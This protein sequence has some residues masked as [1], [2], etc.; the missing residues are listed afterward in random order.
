MSPENHI[1]PRIKRTHLLLRDALIALIS[2][3]SYPAISVQEITE[4]ATLNRATF[5]K[6]YQDKDDLLT[7]SI[8][9]ILDEFINAVKQPLYSQ[10]KEVLTIERLERLLNLVFEH[11]EKNQSLYRIMLV[12]SAVPDFSS[13]L[14]TVIKECISMDINQVTEIPNFSPSV[15]VDIT[16]SFITAAALGVIK[17]WLEEETPFSTRKMSKYLTQLMTTG[18]FNIAGFNHPPH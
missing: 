16:V 5:Y 12:K 18:P 3:K 10:G 2:E 7:K 15:P 1:D 8:D 4:R 11:I 9:G 14:D 6:H 13:R 17:W